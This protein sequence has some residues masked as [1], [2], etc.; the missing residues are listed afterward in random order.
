MAFY[1]AILLLSAI[2]YVIL[3]KTVL[4]VEGKDS[5]LAKALAKDFKGKASVV[6][7]T[8]GI[9]TS[10]YNEWISGAAYF[11]VA[12]SWL[13]PDKRIEKIFVSKE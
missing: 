13:I 7:Y 2:A 10:F 9:V 1:G 8:V 12:M 6:L 3:Q 5:V 11:I 4:D